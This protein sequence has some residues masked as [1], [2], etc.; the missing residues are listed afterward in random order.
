MDKQTDDLKN[1][2]LFETHVSL[3]AR[4]VPFAGWEMPIQYT[5]ILEEARAVRSMCGIFDVSHMGRVRFTGPGA[6]QFLHRILSADIL[7]LRVG[8]ARYNL[9]CNER[10]G[11]HRR[12]PCLSLG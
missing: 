8:R 10:G 4:I 3:G 12:C 2:P 7:G 5:S 9:I 11:H 6:A 1:T